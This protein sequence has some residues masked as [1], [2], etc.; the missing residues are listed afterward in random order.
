MRISE[1]SGET[2]VWGDQT[3][4]GDQQR[5]LGW[6]ALGGR[7]KRI[8]TPQHE[9]LRCRAAAIL[10]ARCAIFSDLGF[11]SEKLGVQSRFL[12]S[13]R[14][15]NLASRAKLRERRS[16]VCVVNKSIPA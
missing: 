15:S 16:A 10:V 12:S 5:A 7:E 9:M 13:L 8:R 2:E 6:R 14:L 4:S 3:T 11:F 1:L